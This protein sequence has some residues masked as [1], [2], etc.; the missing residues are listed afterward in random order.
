M[1][2][3]DRR[4]PLSHILP[5][6]LSF[7]VLVAVLFGFLL[8]EARTH[9]MDVLSVNADM[10][11]ST[12]IRSCVKAAHSAIPVPPAVLYLAESYANWSRSGR[13]DYLLQRWRP[14]SI[15]L[16]P[17]YDSPVD[18]CPTAGMDSARTLLMILPGVA[19][20]KNWLSFAN[21]SRSHEATLRS[22]VLV[23]S[24]QVGL[25]DIGKRMQ[26][27]NRLLQQWNSYIRIT[28]ESAYAPANSRKGL[29]S[30]GDVGTKPGVPQ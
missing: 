2:V 28:G 18:Y 14:L 3:Y 23:E 9:I 1:Q 7:G 5:H 10:R 27:E 6:V 25:E 21:Q 4:S 19:S 17:V 8:R 22:A 15:R 16:L 12:G 24:V 30:C 20:Q 13:D 11:I 26:A 29:I